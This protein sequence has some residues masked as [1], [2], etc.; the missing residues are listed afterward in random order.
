M[1]Y[2]VLE[3]SAIFTQNDTEIRLYVL[4]PEGG[5]GVDSVTI[6]VLPTDNPVASIL[7]PLSNGTYYSDQL[8]TFEGLVS[9]TEDNNTDLSIVWN[10]N[11]DG[12]L[13]LS[14]HPNEAGETLG[15]T[16]LSQG[17]HFLVLTA[18][19]FFSSA[20]IFI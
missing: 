20:F 19:L 5:A 7:K 10:S 4:D 9:D 3:T 12:D 8:I 11:I 18:L 17:D 6:T 15:A 14:V 2:S 13:P 16:Y 1:E